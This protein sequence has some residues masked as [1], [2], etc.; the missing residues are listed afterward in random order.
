MLSYLQSYLFVIISNLAEQLFSQIRKLK[1][2]FFSPEICE[3]KSIPFLM[4]KF[5][6][7]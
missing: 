4:K 3:V 5:R 1:L 2:S 7:I 6:V